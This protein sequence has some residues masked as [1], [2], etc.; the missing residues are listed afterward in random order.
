MPLAFCIDEAGR[1]SL[2]G[3]V[4]AGVVVLPEECPC[5]GYVPNPLWTAIR[6]SKKIGEKA[7]TKIAEYIKSI[8]ITWGIGYA[9]A[10]EVDEINILQATM[11]AMHRAMDEA[12]SKCPPADRPDIIWV[13]G[14]QF[15]PYEPP[16]DNT[17]ILDY[18]CV[19]N[20]DAKYKGIAAASIL[21]KVAHD[22]WIIEYCKAHPEE[23]GPYNLE[24]NK[25]YGTSVHMQAL[26]QDGPHLLHRRSF[27]P[28]RAH[29]QE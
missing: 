22:D 21:A 28:V 19:V 16:G 24:K 7:R 4:C 29:L 5:A 10:R 27:A 1:G 6:D 9:D 25:G 13:D 8:A 12:W 14:P 2:W 18:K 20:G 17:E 11:R 15:I 26:K 3:P 23:I